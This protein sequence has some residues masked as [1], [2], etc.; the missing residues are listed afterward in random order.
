MADAVVAWLTGDQGVRG[1]RARQGVP[2]DVRRHAG[3][4]LCKAYACYL[5]T[6][7]G[8]VIGT[9]YL[10]RACLTFCIYNPLYY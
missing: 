1:G 4:K 8:P 7:S 3:E 5:S 2:P 10:S 9:L 6:T